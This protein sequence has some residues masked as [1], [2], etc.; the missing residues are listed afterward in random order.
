MAESVDSEDQTESPGIGMK[1]TIAGLKKKFP[2]V[3][4]LTTQALS[5]LVNKCKPSEGVEKSE[6]LLIVDARP[7]EEYKVGH[8]ENAKRVNFDAD[9]GEIMND[10]QDSLNFDMKTTVVCYCSVGYRSSMVVEKIVKQLKDKG[11]YDEEK[12]NVYNLEGSIFK[13]AN[14]SRPMVDINNKETK[15][16]HPYNAV[17]GKMLN[18]ELRKTSLD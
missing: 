7:D 3:K 11:Q 12:I 15:C 4:N 18:K 5:A 16:T 2:T 8:I 14:E 17:F 10:I 6:N 9:G 1:I 13:W